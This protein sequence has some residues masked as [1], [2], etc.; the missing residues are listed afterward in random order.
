[1]K[2]A[3]RNYI[4]I[5]DFTEILSKVVKNR[6][7]G[8]LSCTNRI[9]VSLSQVA[10]VVIEAFY[11]KSR[12]VYLKNKENIENNIFTIDDSLFKTINCYLTIS[13]GDGLE[14]VANYRSMP[15]SIA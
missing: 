3:L 2:D 12:V 13:I 15:S 6:I 4:H 8:M 9:D 11:S 14:K 1:M 7:T 5:D 10:N